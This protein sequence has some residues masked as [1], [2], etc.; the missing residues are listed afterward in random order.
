MVFAS[1]NTHLFSRTWKLTH[2][3]VS[4]SKSTAELIKNVEVGCRWL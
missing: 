1:K 4:V 2:L 3:A